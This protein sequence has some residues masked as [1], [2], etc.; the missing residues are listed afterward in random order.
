MNV[1]RADGQKITV[2]RSKCRYPENCPG[3]GNC[4]PFVSMEV[5]MK[6]VTPKPKAIRGRYEP[7]PNHGMTRGEILG[8]IAAF[9]ARHHAGSSTRVVEDLS[10]FGEGRA[11]SVAGCTNRQMADWAAYCHQYDKANA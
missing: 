9:Y 6:N 3:C 4:D 1:T 8:R 11:K 2:D 10:I 7:M 5:P